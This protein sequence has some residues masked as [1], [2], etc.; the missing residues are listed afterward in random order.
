MNYF[1]KVLFLLL[2][3]S[4]P[5]LSQI[6]EG[7]NG[8][9]YMEYKHVPYISPNHCYYSCLDRETITNDSIANYIIDL[10]RKVKYIDKFLVTETGYLF[11]RI[12]IKKRKETILKAKQLDF[13]KLVYDTIPYNYLARIATLEYFMITNQKDINLNVLPACMSLPF[14]E[15]VAV[16]C[17]ERPAKVGTINILVPKMGAMDTSLKRAVHI[18]E[19]TEEWVIE[20]ERQAVEVEVW[21]NR[22][23]F[24]GSFRLQFSSREKENQIVAKLKNIEN[25]DKAFT[26]WVSVAC[27]NQLIHREDSKERLN[28]LANFLNQEGYQVSEDT[29]QLNYELLKEYVEHKNKINPDNKKPHYLKF[30]TPRGTSSYYDFL[31]KYID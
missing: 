8:N 26:D 14:D 10:Q 13:N 30:K 17:Y 11:N 20:P 25:L 7:V 28:H 1:Y 29:E 3:T 6:I 27:D 5:L 19:A 9:G 31:K 16:C 15:C 18:D 12:G 22:T 24:G 21:D 4:L 23:G 2:I